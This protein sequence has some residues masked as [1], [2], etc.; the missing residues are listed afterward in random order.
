MS[1]AIIH[2]EDAV[3]FLTPEEIMELMSAMI[4]HVGAKQ[5]IGSL[6]VKYDGTCLV[7]GNQDGFFVSDQGYF[8]KTPR[9]FRSLDEIYDY[10]CPT[11]KKNKLL[12]SFALLEREKIRPELVF[13]ADWLFDALTLLDGK[14]FQPNIITYKSRFPLDSYRMGLAVHSQIYCGQE[15]DSQWVGKYADVLWAPAHLPYT[16]G[17]FSG[18]EKLFQ[19]VS[20]IDH[21][22]HE[23]SKETIAELRKY[24]NTCVREHD[25]Y[26]HEHLKKFHDKGLNSLAFNLDIL[27][28]FKYLLLMRLNLIAEEHKYFETSIG[29]ELAPHEGFVFRFK[30]HKV[31]LVDRYRFS[32]KNFD[33]S[34][35]RG[36][37]NGRVQT[38]SNSS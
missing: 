15:T 12:T 6:T 30:D 8:N 1:K 3:F 2:L 19:L 14:T 22:K 31:K 20:R 13:H 17:D 23:L 35:V 25:Y 34:A 16:G 33:Q 29:E 5:R 21:T 36:W 18:Y 4:L 27:V 26:S 9:R 10:N 37:Q 32:K 11:G 24:L 7:F 38:I 28:R